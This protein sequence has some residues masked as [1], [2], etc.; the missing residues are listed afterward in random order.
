MR[1]EWPA[2]EIS[3]SAKLT[4]TMYRPQIAFQKKAVTIGLE[5]TKPN[6]PSM[7]HRSIAVDEAEI[8]VKPIREKE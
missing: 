1:C 3:R 6:R 5:L 7:Q 4:F 8:A 2:D